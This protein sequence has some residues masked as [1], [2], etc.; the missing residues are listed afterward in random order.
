MFAQPWLALAAL[1]IA[2]AVIAAH[3]LRRR[4]HQPVPWAAMQFL[5][6]AAAESR[7]R[8]RLERWLLILVRTTLL[9]LLALLVARPIG[10]GLGAAMGFA[11]PGALLVVVDNGLAMQAPSDE[12]GRTLMQQAIDAA[13]P[14]VAGWN[15]PVAILPTCGPETAWLARA[16]LAETALSALPATAGRADWPAVLDAAARALPASGIAAERRTV[17]LLTSL[18]RGNWPD[19]GDPN[20]PANALVAD[21]ARVLLVNVQPAKRQNLTVTDLAVET[22]F[23]GGDLPARAAAT[24]VNRGT[25][26]VTPTA[27]VWSV[28]GREVRRDETG[29]IAAGASRTLLAD[30]PALGGGLHNV[31]VRLA[32]TDDAIDADNQRWAPLDR[33]RDLRVV[34]V[35]PAPL[36]PPADRASLFVT[37]ALRSAAEQSHVPIRIKQIAPAQVAA[38]LEEPADAVLLCDAAGIDAA[39]WQQLARQVGAGCG[40]LAWM[41]PRTVAVGYPDTK[42]G[43]LLPARA[44]SVVGADNGSDWSVQLTE[45]VAPAFAALTEGT[46]A[47]QDLLGSVRQLVEVDPAADATVLATTSAGQPLILLR[48]SERA[49]VALVATSP[50]LAWSTMPG[51]PAFPALVLGLVRQVLTAS[52]PDLQVACGQPIRLPMPGGTPDNMGQWI[53]PDGGSAPVRISLAKG[54]LEAVLPLAAMPGAYQL[55]AGGNDRMVFANPDSLAGDLAEVPARQRDRL[56]RTGV[57]MTDPDEIGPAL[58]GPGEEWT[59]PLAYVLL[60]ILLAELLLTGWFAKA[61]RP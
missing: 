49:G 45:P 21:A 7:S 13:A 42:E 59:G 51:R 1:P 28:D 18:T 5:L 38:A 17:L 55:Q 56:T 60:G 37:A 3:L 33:P 12:E 44:K 9:V 47:G 43:N 25:D 58:A 39:G 11:K 20:E 14:V 15:G 2:A 19:S 40:L 54:R 35:E 24:I 30:L 31:E 16:D 4:R 53:L 6:A 48:R 29:Q 52:S 41:G 46:S 26:P 61:R 10:T 27:L 8:L 34:V 23:A 32:A 22:A 36:A 57:K 50:D